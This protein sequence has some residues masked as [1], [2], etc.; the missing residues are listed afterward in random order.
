MP[1]PRRTAKETVSGPPV[2]V[3]ETRTS[4][5]RSSGPTFSTGTPGARSGTATSARSTALEIGA[6]DSLSRPSAPL[7]APPAEPS[8]AVQAADGVAVCTVA[9]AVDSAPLK[10]VKYSWRD[11]ASKRETTS[12]RPDDRRTVDEPIA[13]AVCASRSAASVLNRS[14]TGWAGT[15]KDDP[16]PIGGEPTRGSFCHSDTSVLNMSSRAALSPPEP[17]IPTSSP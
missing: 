11:D 2:A 1:V 13:S 15:S 7:A 16:A 12:S 17:V 5:V 6:T 3:A 8:S 14:A 10:T 9:V 4:S